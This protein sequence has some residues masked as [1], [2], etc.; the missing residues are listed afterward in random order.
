[1]PRATMC[2]HCGDPVP[3]GTEC[4]CEG[5]NAQR[6]RRAAHQRENARISGRDT[7]HWRH[8]RVARWRRDAWTCQSCGRHKDELGAREHLECHL[9]PA[10]QGNHFVA[11]I[12]RLR[13]RLLG[14]PLVASEG[15]L[16]GRRNIC[17]LWA[18]K[19]SQRWIPR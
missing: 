18:R 4:R 3:I 17:Q 10:L 15:S 19:P 5:A 2:S 16:K 14:L 8:L 13:D 7:P 12:P 6:F 11:T 1:M 9:D